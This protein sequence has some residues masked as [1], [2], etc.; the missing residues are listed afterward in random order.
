M[1]GQFI[2]AYR[3][4]CIK[5]DQVAGSFSTKTFLPIVGLTTE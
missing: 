5:H 2:S 1:T 3:I 4:Y